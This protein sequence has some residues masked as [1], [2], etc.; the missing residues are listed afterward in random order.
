MMITHLFK[1]P[2]RLKILHEVLLLKDD[3]TVTEIQKSTGVSKG[4]VSRYLNEMREEGLLERS[5]RNYHL[6][7]HAITRAIKVLLNLDTLK[8]DGITAEWMISAALYGSWA[9]GTNT[10][11]SDVDIWIKT[12]RI[13]STDELNILY[14]KLKTRT[15]SEI[16]ILILT[17][18]KLESIK[19]TDPPFYHSLQRNSLQLEGESIE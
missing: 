18:E 15:A 12:D 11:E 17:P 8:W 5:G 2:E 19:I 10:E 7:N 1:T 3:I 16:N 6:L 9:S 4:L 13:P 14:K